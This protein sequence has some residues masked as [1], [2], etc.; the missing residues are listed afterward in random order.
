MALTKSIDLTLGTFVIGDRKAVVFSITPDSA[1]LEAGES[2]TTA[3]FGFLNRTDLVL[4]EPKGGYTFAYDRT[5]QKVLAY[6]QVDPADTG[7]ADVPLAAVADDVDISGVGA[8]R[9]I[10][11]GV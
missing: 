5:N 3:D 1:W 11:I 7:G 10:A 4:I 8:V 9:G 6:Q 2:L